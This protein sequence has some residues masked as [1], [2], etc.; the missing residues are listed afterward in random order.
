M[1]FTAAG[2]NPSYYSTDIAL[3]L[4]DRTYF[5]GTVVDT[6]EGKHKLD[7]CSILYCASCKRTRVHFLSISCS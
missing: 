7:V 3:Q 1:D 2:V 5:F 6:P 4:N